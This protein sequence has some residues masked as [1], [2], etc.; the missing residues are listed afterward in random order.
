MN[1]DANFEDLSAQVRNH[2]KAGNIL[3]PQHTSFYR[4]KLEAAIATPGISDMQR[5]EWSELLEVLQKI[6]S[7]PDRSF[8][9]GSAIKG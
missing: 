8:P 6:P 5:T 3:F 2:I 7:L 9:G 4:E 1:N